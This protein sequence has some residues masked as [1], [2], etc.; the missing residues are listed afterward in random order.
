MVLTILQIR[1]ETAYLVSEF[2]PFIVSFVKLN[3]LL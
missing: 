3:Q 1:K 2:C